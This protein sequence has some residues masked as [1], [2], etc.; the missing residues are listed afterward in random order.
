GGRGGWAERAVPPG[1]HGSQACLGGRYCAAPQGIPCR[2][3]DD[4]GPLPDAAVP[5]SG[6]FLTSCRWQ[7]KT[8]W[9]MPDGAPSVGAAGR[10]ESSRLVLLQ[11][12]CGLPTDRRSG[13]GTRVSNICPATRLG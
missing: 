7:P 10:K 6:T 8:C 11:S 1:A 2:C 13:S 5:G 4:S 3:A 12:A 9:P